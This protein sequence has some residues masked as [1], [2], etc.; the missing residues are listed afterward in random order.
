M[1]GNVQK[2]CTQVRNPPNHSKTIG[3]AVLLVIEKRNVII[4]L[5]TCN[6]E[7][8]DKYDYSVPI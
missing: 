5:Y 7:P 8:K 4:C 3:L 1:F 2:F 6:I